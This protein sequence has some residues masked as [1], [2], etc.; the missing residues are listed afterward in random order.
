MPGQ[1]TQ[2]N[3]PPARSA[4]IPQGRENDWR[5][6]SAPAV[7]FLDM[8]ID[9]DAMYVAPLAITNGSEDR[10]G[11]VTN[12]DGMIDAAYK[13][14]PVVFLQHSHRL[15][16]LIPPIG[17]AETPARVYDV[18]RKGDTW[19]SGCRFSQS[20]KFATQ[21]FAMVADGVI[22]ARSIGA[23][24]HALSPYRPKMPGVAFHQNQIIPVRTKSVSHDKYEL[25]EWSWVFIP[26]NRDMVTPMKSIMSKGYIDGRP[27]DADLKMI[28]KTFD[29]AE[30]ASSAKHSSKK[31]RFAWPKLR[32]ENIV[33]SPAQILFNANNYTMIEVSAFMKKNADLGI[34]ET[35]ITTTTIGGELFLKSTQFAHSGGF[36]VCEDAKVPGLKVLFA[37]A[38]P[39][40]KKPS[41]AVEQLVSQPDQGV[42]TV[43]ENPP[44]AAAP[45]PAPADPANPQAV[46]P[47]AKAAPAAPAP[48]PVAGVPEDPAAQVGDN[49]AEEAA[50]KISGPGGMKYLKA[51][52]KRATEVTDMAEA[53]QADL[54]PELL[55]KCGEFTN[56]LRAFIGKVS[57]FEQERYGKKKEPG[58]A[59]VPGEKPEEDEET[60]EPS[61]NLTKSAMTGLFYGTKTRLPVGFV[62][63]LRLLQEETPDEK[64]R[65]LIG[66]MMKGVAIP[67]PKPDPDKV[68]RDQVRAAL[69]KQRS[70]EKISQLV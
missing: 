59:A 65:S 42:V 52:I 69:I 50:E 30:P 14:N 63:G 25:V 8:V 43:N 23:L 15:S 24:N 64:H 47:A 44:P 45:A 51:L 26:S 49:E 22:R 60:K 53:A 13:T 18:S 27:I 39:E 11:E 34:V 66:L 46:D 58:A 33:K 21:V 17:T 68:L 48:V 19:F 9:E 28:M 29:L 38:F 32:G 4:L 1:L 5:E 12:P 61:A 57:E 56:T 16:P 40:D 36:E 31:P 62:H 3:Q 20:T 10:D 7:S 37:K 41:T 70:S 54:E 55:E 6:V 35:P 2:L 67:E